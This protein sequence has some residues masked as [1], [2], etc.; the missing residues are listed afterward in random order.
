MAKFSICI[1]PGH[2]GRDRANRGKN[3]YVEADGMLKMS[4]YLRDELLKTGLFDVYMTRETDISVSLTDRA[5]IAIDNNCDIFLSQHSNAGGGRGVE[6]FRSILRPETQRLAS[7]LT[8]AKASF[9]NTVNRGVKTKESTKVSGHDYFTVLFETAKKVKYP[10]L[11]ESLFHD[12]VAE[13]IIL[14]DHKNLERLATLQSDI[15]TNYFYG[16]DVIRVPQDEKFLIFNGSK[17]TI[18]TPVINV[19]GRLLVPVREFF[20]LL[21]YEVVNWSATKKAATL[22]NFKN[23][24]ELIFTAGSTMF[25]DN[26]NKKELFMDQEA[27]LKNHVLMI[28]ITFLRILNQDI[29]IIDWNKNLKEAVII[30]KNN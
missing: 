3:G 9:F 28:P 29:D 19:N 13:E 14:L 12:N 8:V 6:V 23:Q 22:Y 11:I 16:Y 21:D 10:F 20:K 1:D 15:L 4:L 24:K 27:I 30:Q 26:K 2:G 18:R 5:K 17:K 7:M 25:F